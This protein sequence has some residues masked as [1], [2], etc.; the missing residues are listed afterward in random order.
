MNIRVGFYYLV[1]AL[2]FTC[3]AIILFPIGIIL[4]WPALSVLV[5]AI[6]Y[7]G[8]GPGIYGKKD[9]RI[10]VLSRIF[11]FFFFHGQEL[12][13]RHYARNCRAWDEIVPGLLIGRKLDD[14]EAKSLVSEGVVAVVDLTAEFEE[15][16]PLREL[17][18]L[19]IA[20]LDLTAPSEE[21][22]A[23]AIEFISEHLLEGKVYVH[24]KIGYSRTATVV[25]R[26][27]LKAGHVDSPADSMRLL[28]EVRPTIFIRPEAVAAIERH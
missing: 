2:V 4:I 9:G 26:Y 17:H 19:N 28:K 15:A 5:V 6:G 18:Y 23:R 1:T 21:E 27:L 7:F 14:A 3:L 12:S 20:L 16:A 22:M 24:C 8:M 11:H 13:R 10:P 25:A